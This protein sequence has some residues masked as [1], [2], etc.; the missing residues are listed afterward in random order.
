[1][2]AGKYSVVE[3]SND[4][5]ELVSKYLIIPLGLLCNFFLISVYLTKTFRGLVLSFYLILLSITNSLILILLFINILIK[6]EKFQNNLSIRFMVYFEECLWDICSWLVT[7][8]AID[9]VIFFNIKKKKLMSIPYHILITLILIGVV[10]S[11]NVMILYK[12]R[13]FSSQNVLIFKFNYWFTFNSSSEMCTTFQINEH[14]R[15]SVGQFIKMVILHFAI[16]LLLTTVC[17]MVTIF[18]IIKIKR[19][20]LSY[21]L[22]DYKL[23]LITVFSIVAYFFV[24]LPILSIFIENF[25]KIIFL[26]V[27]AKLPFCFSRLFDDF[28]NFHLIL[29]NVFLV[30][31]NCYSI[32]VFFLLVFCNQ[33]FRKEF[34]NIL[35]FIKISTF[36]STDDNN[37]TNFIIQAFTHTYLIQFKKKSCLGS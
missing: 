3:N 12:T 6:S 29:L 28:E 34:L 9:K 5:L 11:A 21:K 7:F 27:D 19:S 2:N 13:I 20:Y 37:N 15:S 31:R 1:M 26:L 32:F 36:K 16:P 10:F 35:K 25:C 30:F 8:I 22:R 23:L 18:R 4:I 33:L 24:T 17:F 14:D